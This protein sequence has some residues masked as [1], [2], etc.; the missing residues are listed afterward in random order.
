MILILNLK[1]KIRGVSKAP[2]KTPSAMVKDGR[3]QLLLI[4][5]ATGDLIRLNL[6][7]GKT[8]T[9]ASGFGKGRLAYDLYG[10]LFVSNDKGIS[11][12]PR[13]GT[14]LVPVLA[15]V[16]PTALCVDP[17]GERLLIMT[18]ANLSAIPT[19][20]PGHE[21]NTE[22]LAV[23]AKPAFQK[24]K[25][26]GWSAEDESGKLREMR[27]IVL[28]HAGDGSN[29]VFVATQRGVIHVLPNDQKATKTKVF[30]DISKRV[31]YQDKM[32]EEGLLGLAFHPK[33]KENGEFFVYYTTSK[34]PHTSVV[35]RFRV[36][37]DPNK[38]DPS[39]EEEI[40]T[41]KQPFWN[42]NGGTICFGPDGCLYI[43]LGDGGKANDPLLNGQDL[44]TL[45]GSVLRVDIDRKE[46][47]KKYA[48]PK[49]NPF[50]GRAEAKPE[51]WVYGL[52]NPW[53]ISF[54]RKTG[55]CWCG[56]VGQNLY[57]EINIL[58]S[59]GNYGWNLREAYHPFD[60]DGVGY[61]KDLIDPIWE[62]HHDVG[63][64]ITGG[65][66]YRGKSLPELDGAYL[67]ADYIVGKVWA[68]KYD[69]AKKRVVAN[70]PIRYKR[71]L[72]VLSFGEDEMGEA[73][74]L[75]TSP[76]GKGIFRLERAK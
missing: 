33:Y 16:R 38:A 54:D 36:S 61:R 42:H 35:S 57:E 71:N 55:K 28:T 49:D 75:T 6:F 10:R 7:T 34:A 65:I 22:P 32:N 21:V 12:F 29:R 25:W 74:F 40:M 13:P 73:Y 64:S 9:V 24:V 3:G 30:L 76:T 23:E 70:Q 26:T 14:K 41:I 69:P 8:K 51:I 18:S 67:Y 48:I 43:A 68:L 46:G 15:G 58:T 47:G 44:Q 50:V 2:I 27:P 52:R 31:T 66:V 53:R 37:K 72:P 45:L 56:E 11:A 60:R 5:A 39:S 19:N 4:E 62:Y 63:K 59:G 20:I 17:I 1:K